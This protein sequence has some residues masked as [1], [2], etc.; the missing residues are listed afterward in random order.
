[1][2]P[3]TEIQPTSKPLT[4]WEW[5]RSVLSE[6]TGHGSWSRVQGGLA[7]VLAAAVVALSVWTGHDIPPGAQTVLLGL[8]GSS[9]VVYASNVG[10]AA[11]SALASRK[12]KLEEP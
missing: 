7:F 8:L 2:D 4:F 10:S 12:P 9:G 5:L 6:D 3:L 11:L 1:M